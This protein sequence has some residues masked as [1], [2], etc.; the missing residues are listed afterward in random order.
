MTREEMNLPNVLSGLR[1]LAAPVMLVLAWQGLERPFVILLTT[2]FITDALDGMLARRWNQVTE[3]GARLDSWG[4]LAIYIT[5]ICATYLLWSDLLFE[6]AWFVFPAIIGVL[7]VPVVNL[8]KFRSL[9][10]YHTWL[11]KTAAVCIF[12]GGF[13]LLTGGPAWPFQIACVLTVMST[14][15][16]VG[17]AL[18]LA[19]KRS[20]VKSI[21][22]VIRA[23]R[24]DRPYD[25]VND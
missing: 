1:L 18:Y 14:L 6:N 12:I 10:A 15:E 22:H 9:S 23:G 7:T 13:I 20:N 8:I 5:L 19:E 21:W 4:D 24:Q 17:I 3:L 11:T 2:A 16:Q 25:P